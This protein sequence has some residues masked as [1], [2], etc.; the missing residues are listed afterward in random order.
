MVLQLS[1]L[2]ALTEHRVGS[3]RP[4]V[5][6]PPGALSFSVFVT[7]SRQSESRAVLLD[8]FILCYIVMRNERLLRVS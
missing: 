4:S 5:T 2:V 3:S 7:A 6:L 8:C 1:T